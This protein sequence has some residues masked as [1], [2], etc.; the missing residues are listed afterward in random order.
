[1]RRHLVLLE[2]ERDNLES[3]RHFCA[4]LVDCREKLDTLDAQALLARMEQLEQEGTTF[5]DKQ[6][7]DFKRRRY[8]APVLS[9]VVMALLMG[10][11][12]WLMMWAFEVDPLGAPPLPILLLLIAMPAVVILGVGI[13]LYQRIREIGRGKDDDYKKY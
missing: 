1:M 4:E 7:H 10:G 13:A 2:R 8:V 12:I 11:M 6:K 9:A 5:M 3:A